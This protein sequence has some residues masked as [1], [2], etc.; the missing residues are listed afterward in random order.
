MP[1]VTVVPL[2][3]TKPVANTVGA[4][5]LANLLAVPVPVTA[6]VLSIFSH[7]SLAPCSINIAQSP[8]CQSVI[9]SKFVL[10]A[11]LTI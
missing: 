5:H 9:P 7:W 11:T 3:S 8:T 6:D 10:P 1:I 2:S 4:V